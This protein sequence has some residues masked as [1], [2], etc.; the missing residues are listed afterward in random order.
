[1]DK[2]ERQGEGENSMPLFNFSIPEILLIGDVF[3]LVPNNW[4]LSKRLAFTF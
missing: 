4:H 1:M 3:R 2:V